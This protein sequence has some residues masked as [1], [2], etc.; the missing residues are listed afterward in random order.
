MSR[1]RDL[2]SFVGDLDVGKRR[3]MRCRSSGGR[4]GLY[5]PG[6]KQRQA[7]ARA[8]PNSGVAVS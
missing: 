3:K 5:S 7:R 1:A 2:V 6:T 8:L 4:R